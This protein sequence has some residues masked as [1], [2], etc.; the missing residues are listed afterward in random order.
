MAKFTSEDISK[1]AERLK[2][3]KN[4]NHPAHFLVG[5]GCSISAGIP[6]AKELIEKIHADYP[7]HCETLGQD[8]RHI[9]GACMNLLTTNER[10]DLIRPY[11]EEAK[12]NWGTIALAQLIA[13]GFVERVLTVNF[14]LVLE[15]ACGLLGLQPAIYDFG[16]APA[17]D[18]A[19]VVEPAVIHLHG[20]SYGLILLNTDDETKKH[21][22]KL[23]PILIDTLRKAPLVVIGYSGSA[24]GISQNLLDEFEGREPIYWVGHNEELPEHLV[25]FRKKEHFHFMGGTDFDRFMIELAQSL[26]CW[27][28]HLFADPVGHLLNSLKP[29]VNYPIVDSD[30]SIDLL[31]HLRQ[32]LEAWRGEESQQDSLQR[33]YMKGDYAAATAA[34]LSRPD[35]DSVPDEDREMAYWS[36]V[37]WGDALADRARRASGEKALQLFTQAGERYAAALRIKP[38]HHEALYNWGNALTSQAR[39]EDRKEEASRLFAEAKEKYAASLAIKPD[40]HEALNNWGNVLGD[41]AKRTADKGEA[42]RLFAEAEEKYAASLAILPKKHNALDNWGSLLM[43]QAKRVGGEEAS[44]L[45]ASA[46]EKLGLAKKIDPTRSYNLACL[47]ALLGDSEQCRQHLQSADRHHSLP[48]VEHLASDPDIDSVRNQS[49]FKELLDRQR[50]KTAS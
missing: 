37:G 2:G 16:V 31:R 33:L 41:E 42:S 9:Y 23:Q 18:P 30:S 19:M 44:R 43:E 4:R 11:L 48:N 32:K 6:T 15:N 36:F 20:Q 17:N 3:A 1:L 24:D 34:F 26:G 50:K 49:W 14:D 38:D 40:K 29:V 21:Q 45:F 22:K 35:P 25:G 28:P 10:R 12:I 27:P 47:A 8:K 46:A 5:A 39:R 7:K 13:E